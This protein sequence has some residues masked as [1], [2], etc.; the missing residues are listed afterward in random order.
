MFILN[1]QREKKKK[2]KK[3]RKI[4]FLKI[5]LINIDYVFFYIKESDFGL[6][7]YLNYQ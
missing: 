7:F 4:I 5:K 2:N 6:I 1:N 3:N